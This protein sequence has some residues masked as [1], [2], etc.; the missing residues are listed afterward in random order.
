MS[1]GYDV[2]ESSPER[3]ALDQI[4]VL[5]TGSTGCAPASVRNQVW[6]FIQAHDIQLQV[7]SSIRE[8]L[9]AL[10]AEW[11]ETGYE[12]PAGSDLLLKTRSALS[13]STLRDDDIHFEDKD[14]EEP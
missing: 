1:E 3:V 5:L 6:S 12:P 10:L 11:L 9:L 14:T 13:L 8:E 2:G 7:A 4:T